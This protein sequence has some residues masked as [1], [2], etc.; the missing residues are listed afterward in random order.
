MIIELRKIRGTKQP[1][2]LVWDSTLNCWAILYPSGDRILFSKDRLADVIKY[3]WTIGSA[4]KN[5]RYATTIVWKN[6]KRKNMRLHRY[7]CG[8]KDGDGKVVDHKNHD[9]LDNRDENLH[10]GNHLDNNNNSYHRPGKYGP[11]IRAQTLKNGEKRYYATVSFN[12]KRYFSHPYKSLS[13]AQEMYTQMKK[14]VK[15]G[16][17]I[18]E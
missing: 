2:N 8:L 1:I 7:L 3:N 12:R 4:S 18:H 9:T 5:Y 15:K 6:G 13:E 17:Y 14:I 11:G 10:V 16:C